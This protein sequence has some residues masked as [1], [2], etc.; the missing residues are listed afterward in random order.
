MF[1]RYPL[2]KIRHQVVTGLVVVSSIIILAFLFIP[3]LIDLEIVKQRLLSQISE[4]TGGKY[5]YQQLDL[6][7]FPRPRIVI[8]SGS[9]ALPEDQYVNVSSVNIYPM[10][11]PLLKGEVYFKRIEVIKPHSQIRI[12]EM[13]LAGPQN[14]EYSKTPKRLREH[15]IDILNQTAL[16]FP[17]VEYF[18][19]NGRIDFLGAASSHFHIQNIDAQLRYLDNQLHMNVKCQSNVGNN[20]LL[21]GWIQ[22]EN[23]T[24]NGQLRIDRFQPHLL[25]NYFFLKI[26]FQITESSMNLRLNLTSDSPLQTLTDLTVSNVYMRIQNEAEKVE[27]KGRNAQ[28]TIRTKPRST[29]VSLSKFLFDTPQMNVSGHL[30]IDHDDPEVGLELSGIDL[31]IDPLRKTAQ[32]IGGGNR[33]IENIF[34]II[35]GGKVPVI[36]ISGRGRSL[37]DLGRIENLTV[38]G[39]MAE[40]QIFIP[41]PK[42]QLKNVM[43]DT[44]IYK[45]ILRGNRLQATLGESN[46][47]NG[48]LTLGL[49]GPTPPFNLEIDTVADISQLRHI[50]LRLVRYDILR[51]ELK[52]I[53]Q[54]TGRAKGRLIIG[55]HLDTIQIS[56]DITEAQIK[57]IYDRIPVPIEISGGTYEL[58][59]DRITGHNFDVK[60]GQSI[61][62]GISG[63]WQWNPQSILTITAKKSRVDL[64][65]LHLWLGDFDSLKQAMSSFQVK[66]GVADLSTLSVTRNLEITPNY[67]FELE[68]TVRQASIDKGQ[69]TSSM[70]MEIP[71]VIFSTRSTESGATEI[72]LSG[73]QIQ[74]GKG[75]MDVSGRAQ[76]KDN[77]INLDLDVSADTLSWDLFSVNNQNREKTEKDGSFWGQRIR[78]VIRVKTATFTYDSWKWQSILAKVIFAPTSATVAIQKADLCGIPF[79][80]KIRITP[81]NVQVDFS[82]QAREKDLAP[83]FACFWNR[84]GVVT[85]QYSLAASLNNQSSEAG[86]LRS[87]NGKLDFEARSGRIHRY[88]ILSKILALLNLTEVFK[89]KLPDIAK[90]GFAFDTI[91][92]EGKFENGKFI[93]EEGIIN[94]SSMTVIYQGSFNMLD[95]TLKLTVFVSPFKTIDSIIKK[96]P[97]VNN[98]LRGRFVS[99]P[100]A[101]NGKWSNYTV[102]PL[103]TDPSMRHSPLTVEN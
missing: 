54:L 81:D 85:G 36:S 20:I 15:M 42:L 17:G 37:A 29:I 38:K 64:N 24:G 9:L 43:G 86:L 83:D 93:L 73:N 7:W 103:V 35:A 59:H 39:T 2:D 88:G 41:G 89:G 92:A 48:E 52:H 16:I 46:G 30:F 84:E 34:K 72:E 1:T 65:A 76:V 28:A 75:R 58:T 77:I 97:L 14:I 68:G 25:L 94:G 53:S 90:E 67:H 98:V 100:F 45:G 74:W 101:V 23:F 87:L 50:L 47:Y 61:F 79:P 51:E 91:N 11:L 66:S 96:I 57:G 102:T 78:G 82:P 19:R 22:P 26:P 56:A 95:E 40:G 55:D 5:T 27:M 49:L 4:S 13:K 60:M 62:S 71:K 70:N 12:H 3:R 31:H 21:T 8:L 69:T 80:G 18:I 6:H 10:I 44:T 33:S 99:I 63:E 32:I